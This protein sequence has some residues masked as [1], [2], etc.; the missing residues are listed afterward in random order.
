MDAHLRARPSPLN[1]LL[2]EAPAPGSLTPI[3]P[4]LYWLR[5][6]L[7]F[8]LNHVNLW[9]IREDSGWAIIDTGIH[10]ESTRQTWQALFNPQAS[11]LPTPHQPSR[12][13]AT[14]Y[15]PDHIGCAGW[16]T[17]HYGIPLYASLTEWSYGR[18]ISLL[19]ETVYLETIG[20][21]YQRFGLPNSEVQ[22][23]RDYGNHYARNVSPL[24]PSL[25]TLHHGDGLKIGAHDWQVMTFGGHSPDHVCLYSADAKILIAGDQVL[26]FISP[27]ISTSFFD[28]DADPLRIYLASLAVL[29]TLPDD[30]L[31]LPSHGIPFRNLHLRIDQLL[32]HHAERLEQVR[33][34]CQPQARSV[35]ELM[36][37]MFKADLDSHQIMFAIGEA[38]AHANHLVGQGHLQSFEENGVLLYRS[39]EV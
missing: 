38:A 37:H 18:M 8:R 31:V 22:R 23:M 5:L 2:P 30:T 35:A 28:A 10:N 14:H 33:L 24:P 6:Q 11:V 27:N 21:F 17:E 7:P 25:H 26:P 32:Q 15:H 39:S 34:F 29:R 12:V 3:A 4:D 36:A 13:I 1:L 9:L 19:P 16:L 20:R